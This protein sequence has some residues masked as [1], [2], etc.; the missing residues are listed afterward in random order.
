MSTGRDSLGN[1]GEARRKRR[2]M[3]A[4]REVIDVDTGQTRTV[5]RRYAGR[6]DTYRRK[7]GETLPEVHVPCNGCTA[8][9]CHPLVDIHPILDPPERLQHL[10][11]ERRE[12]GTL[13]LKRKPDGACVHL[14][15]AGCTVY[16]HR[17]LGCRAYDCRV[18]SLLDIVMSYDGVH[19]PPAWTFEAPTDAEKAYIGALRMGFF[20]H[21]RQHPGEDPAIAACCAAKNVDKFLPGALKMVRIM[22]QMPKEALQEL[23]KQYGPGKLC[24]LFKPKEEDPNQ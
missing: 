13:A 3:K 12:D 21:L 16:Q 9:C 19:F 15:P 22:Q 4:T 1:M 5:E 23:A 18:L 20:E 2:A 10:D 7:L 11:L 24:H 6:V 14:G 8:C 17:P